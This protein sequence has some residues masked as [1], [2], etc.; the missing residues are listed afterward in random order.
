MPNYLDNLD[1]E[2]ASGDVTNVLL[3][4][5]GTLALA[6]TLASHDVYP[7]FTKD[8]S[9]THGFVDKDLTVGD[10]NRNK[11]ESY[12]SAS[13]AIGSIDGQSPDG[14]IGVF[15]ASSTSD[16][17]TSVEQYPIGV[18]GLAVADNENNNS[19]IGSGYF[20][21]IR[22]ENTSGS[23][24]GVEI[25]CD[26]EVESQDITPNTIPDPLQDYSS[27]LQLSSGGGNH[28]GGNSKALSTAM[29]INANPSKF[30]HG[31]VITDGS[32]TE[33][34]ICLPN[35]GRI[36]WWNDKNNI[37]IDGNR[38]S[39]YLSGVDLNGYGQFVIG[40]YNRTT[41]TYE[42]FLVNRYSLMPEGYGIIDIAEDS[43]TVGEHTL[44]INTAQLP[45]G[46]HI[47]GVL[48]I[49]AT[50]DS[51]KIIINGWTNNTISIYVQQAVT[52]RLQPICCFEH[53]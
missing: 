39:V 42:Q 9:D 30:K 14:C 18:M 20:H 40:M 10:T 1:V 34:A 23:T 3:Q 49:Q 41:D 21:I 51:G 37:A 6:N 29:C 22:K 52:T 15:G 31:M 17:P 32:V 27:A 13:S 46:Y 8:A 2:D 48:N 25:D 26:V 5:R 53:D 12:V 11:Y 28:T 35:N 24:I 38:P 47:K 50:D 4:D 33:E 19:D 44:Q 43:Y 45:S 36:A 16:I 7:V